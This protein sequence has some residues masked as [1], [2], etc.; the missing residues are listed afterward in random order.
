MFVCLPHGGSCLTCSEQLVFCQ[1]IDA[2]L[3]H[4]HTNT[5]IQRECCSCKLLA[6][7]G[8]ALASMMALAMAE[9]EVEE[10]AVEKRQSSVEEAV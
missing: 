2:P 3:Q 7:W 1:L 8:R 5:H 4:T 10:G 6:R 9:D